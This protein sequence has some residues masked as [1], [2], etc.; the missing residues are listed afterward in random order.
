MSDPLG[1]YP[2]DTTNQDFNWSVSEGE[3]PLTDAAAEKAAHNIMLHHARR[4]HGLLNQYQVEDYIRD[5]FRDL[6]RKLAERDDQ[7]SFVKG[8][9]NTS[10]GSRKIL[11]TWLSEAQAKHAEAR[12]ALEAIA[13][14]V[15]AS[16]IFAGAALAR[17][18]SKEAP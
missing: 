8:L 2:D 5:E 1:E 4:G 6:E 14:G 12:T 10:E 16:N 18:D 3:T 9:L 17:I 7:L 11:G 15:D 13:L